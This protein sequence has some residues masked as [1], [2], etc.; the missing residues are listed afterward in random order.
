MKITS[1]PPVPLWE[2]HQFIADALLLQND[3]GDVQTVLA[4]LIVLGENRKY[5]PIDDALIVSY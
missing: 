4:V 3:I 1:V 5:L 2:P